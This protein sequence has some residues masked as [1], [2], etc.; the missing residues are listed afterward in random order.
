[1]QH[2]APE[3]VF[4]MV[5]HAPQAYLQHFPVEFY[6]L[7]FCANANGALKNLQMSRMRSVLINALS[8][9]PAPQTTDIS[10][11]GRS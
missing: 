7:S 4:Y 9:C 2:M 8:L 3:I 11:G 1:M 10:L 6:A 5:C